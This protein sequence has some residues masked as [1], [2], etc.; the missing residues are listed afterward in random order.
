MG[1]EFLST[2]GSGHVCDDDVMCDDDRSRKVM[3]NSRI[4]FL[5]RGGKRGGKIWALTKR[6]Y[7]N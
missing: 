7:R 5:S 4:F 2:T 3:G 1:R 6:Q